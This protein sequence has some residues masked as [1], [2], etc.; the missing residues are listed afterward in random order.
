MQ[1]CVLIQP[2]LLMKVYKIGK[3]KDILKQ[4]RNIFMCVFQVNQR[5]MK[6]TLKLDPHQWN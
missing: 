1:R 6:P 5:N 3:K 2:L 4:F